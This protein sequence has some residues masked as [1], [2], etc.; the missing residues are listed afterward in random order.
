MFLNTNKLSMVG[1]PYTTLPSTLNK[2][3]NRLIVLSLASNSYIFPD[4]HKY[5]MEM[6]I[7]VR[8]QQNIYTI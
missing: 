3:M 4:L 1:A 2:N 8:G 5:E 6:V 7:V